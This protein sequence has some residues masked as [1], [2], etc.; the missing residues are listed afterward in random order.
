MEWVRFST[1][2]SEYGQTAHEVLVFTQ[3]FQFIEDT[4]SSIEIQ[5]AVEEIAESKQ[6]ST[7]EDTI[8][9]ILHYD[10]YTQ[11]LD[12]LEQRDPDSIKMPEREEILEK[13]NAM[14]NEHLEFE[15]QERVKEQI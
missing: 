2:P 15:H 1:T 9:R 4:I 7:V 14:L 3:V 8:E 10:E 12:D 5:E 11:L 13:L 6:K